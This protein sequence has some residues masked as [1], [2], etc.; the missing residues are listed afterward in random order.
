MLRVAS[1]LF[2]KILTI[3]N[4]IFPMIIFIRTREVIRHYSV[5]PM[6]AL[7]YYV[8]ST[9]NP[10]S[11]MARTPVISLVRPRPRQ[12]KLILILMN[13]SRNIRKIPMYPVGIFMQRQRRKRYRYT[14][15]K[16]REVLG[17]RVPSA[18]R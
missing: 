1:L 7:K 16:M 3:V 15:W 13:Y 14:R 4:H 6:L 18:N 11:R 8:I 12:P 17:R 9:N 10:P 2:F 5:R